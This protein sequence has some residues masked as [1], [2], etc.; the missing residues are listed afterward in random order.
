MAHRVPGART[1][2]GRTSR[3]ALGSVCS[4]NCSLS[5]VDRCKTLRCGSLARLRTDS[6]CRACASLTAQS[7]VQRRSTSPRAVP[8]KKPKAFRRI[9]TTRFCSLSAGASRPIRSAK[10]GKPFGFLPGTR[11]DEVERLGTSDCAV[12]EA[13]RHSESVRRRRQENRHRRVLHRSH[14]IKNNSE[15]KLIRARI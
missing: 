15:S 2:S 13:R 4:R 7:E 8:G 10:T 9:A 6:E 14:L 12:R 3:S 1:D 5:D 11:E